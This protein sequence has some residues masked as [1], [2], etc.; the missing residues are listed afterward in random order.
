MYYR[1]VLVSPWNIVLPFIWR[2]L[3]LCHPG[4]LCAKFDWP[5]SLMCYRYYL[6]LKKNVGIYLHKYEFSLPKLALCQVLLKLAFWFWGRILKYEKFTDRRTEIWRTKVDQKNSLQFS[7]L[8]S[9]NLNAIS[10]WN[11]YLHN[12]IYISPKFSEQAR[13]EVFF[14]LEKIY[15]IVRYTLPGKGRCPSLKRIW[16]LFTFICSLPCLVKVGW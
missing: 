10:D 15:A 3:N 2:N 8:M 11:M 7:A 13:Q 9:L 5:S 4:M 16:I 6:H 1:F 12:S 14:Y